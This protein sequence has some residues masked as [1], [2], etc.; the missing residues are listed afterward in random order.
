MFLATVNKPKQLLYLSYI[1]RVGVEELERGRND[2]VA[3]LADLMA[4]FRLVADLSSLETMDTNCAKE[5]GEVMDLCQQK[6]VA[7]VVRI[8][9]DP[10]K[11]IGMNIL[12]LF[13]YRRGLR[14]VTCAK[15]AE[16]G[17]LLA[18]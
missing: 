15:L 10:Q 2:I 6:G 18:L 16:A 7:L 17:K 3:L 12:S 4:G 8:I 13:H 14:I 5:I 9:P 11:D 1:Q